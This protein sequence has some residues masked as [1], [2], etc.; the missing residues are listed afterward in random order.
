MHGVGMYIERRCSG[1]LGQKWVNFYGLFVQSLFLCLTFCS[2]FITC[3][4]P[5]VL[6]VS[7]T[8]KLN[9]WGWICLSSFLCFIR[10]Q[11]D[12]KMVFKRLIYPVL[13]WFGNRGFFFL[14]HAISLWFCDASKLR[15]LFQFFIYLLPT[16]LRESLKRV[17]T[18]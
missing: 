14:S 9:L 7:F 17:K 13:V 8:Q 10:L 4:S 18:S 15:W 2:V 11:Q 5:F 12:L 1:G 16:V 6:F 3:C